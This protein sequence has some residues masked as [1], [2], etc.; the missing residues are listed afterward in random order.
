MVRKR[1][2]KKFTK[3]QEDI[4]YECWK[5]GNTYKEKL[6]LLEKELPNI[7]HPD[8]LSYMRKASKNDTKWL[9]YATRKK[10]E[11]EKEKLE[12]KKEREK[13]KI[14]LAKKRKEREERRRKREE[15]QKVKKD[16]EKVKKNLSPKHISKICDKVPPEFFYCPDV[17][18]Y[19][20]KIS[21]IYRVFGKDKKY[22]YSPD[23]PCSS[24]KRMDKYMDIIKEITKSGRQK[25]RS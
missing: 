24:C 16:K 10:N 7:S 2:K 22:N 12:K 18:Q 14:I 20:N 15:R 13:K 11:K 8:A 19:V 4:I 3:K 21:C 25:K 5:N 6:A 9:K 23:G 1:K 17:K